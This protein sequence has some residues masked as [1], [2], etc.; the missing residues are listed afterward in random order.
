MTEEA[1]MPSGYR[2]CVFVNSKAQHNLITANIQLFDANQT[3]PKI[4]ILT[5]SA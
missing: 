4:I 5:L 2:T 3:L 1:N